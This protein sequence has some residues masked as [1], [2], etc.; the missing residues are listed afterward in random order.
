MRYTQQKEPAVAVVNSFKFSRYNHLEQDERLQISILLKKGYSIREIAL[1]LGRSPSSVSREVRRNKMVKSDTY[2][3]RKAQHKSRVRRLYSKYQGMKVGLN[4]KIQRYV[5][6]KMKLSWSPEA[7]AGRL[8]LETR[9]KL[10]LSP[11]TIY[12]YI[13]RNPLGYNL[14]SFLRY[15]QYRRKKRKLIKNVRE[16]IKDRVFIDQRPD[17]INQRLRYGDFEGDTMGVPKYTRETIAAVVER[18]S[19]FIIGRKISRLK[20]AMDAFKK[21]LSFGKALSATFDNGVENVRHLELG[22]STYFC[23]SYSSWEKGLI[24]NAFSL[25]REYI[26]K[27]SCLRNYS[28]SDIQAIINIINERPRKCLSFRTPKEVFEEH[29]LSANSP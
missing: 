15:K 12:K 27:K 22:I 5:H 4:P 16:I 24:E 23:H 19:R 20:Y 1:A 26:P 17:V 18:K 29:L 7:V 11:E 28:N 14:C 8:K 13:Y 9:G 10:S 21:L 6:E 2:D 3:A 25:I